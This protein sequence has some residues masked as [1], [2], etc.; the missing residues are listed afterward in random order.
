[1]L[2]EGGHEDDRH[3]AAEQLQHLEAVELRH[4]DVE[5][6]EV[7]LRARSPPSPP[8][9]R[10]GTRPRSRRRARGRRYSRSSARAGSSSST[11]TTRRRPGGGK[12]GAV[13]GVGRSPESPAARSGAA[14]PAGPA[15]RSPATRSGPPGALARQRSRTRWRTGRRR[16]EPLLAQ[17]RRRLLEDGV[18]RLDPGLAPE[19]RLAREHLVE[20]GAEGE[21]VAARV[22]LRA[23]HLLGR[24][25]GGGAEDAAGVRVAPARRVGAAL[26]GR[27][28]A[29]AASRGRSR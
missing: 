10:S 5:E 9:S 4:L 7:G 8:R 19:G 28:R 11:I 23:P 13:A 12:P 21:E 15:S 14:P 20:E 17:P 24:H 18:Q 26:E 27:A 22:H 16:L 2:V 6:E 29:G 3:V 1:M 25:V